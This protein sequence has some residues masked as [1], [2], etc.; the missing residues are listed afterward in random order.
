MLS[1]WMADAPQRAEPSPVR[2]GFL[3]RA[4][5]DRILAAN[6]GRA[7]RGDLQVHTLGSDGADSIRDIAAAARARGL[8][9]LAI[10]DHSRG[11][12]IV[13]GMSDERLARQD[14][15]SS[16]QQLEVD[17]PVASQPV[18]QRDHD[19]VEHGMAARDDPQVTRSDG[20]ADASVA[21]GRPRMSSSRAEG[22]SWPSR[23]RASASPTGSYR[24]D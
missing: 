16:R 8:R 19:S 5:C 15:G 10:T 20:A 17:R 1:R 24:R 14:D 6:A 9:Y 21:F 13:H 7:V 4:E 22:A 12:A 3:T 11:L 23:A 18:H 2:R